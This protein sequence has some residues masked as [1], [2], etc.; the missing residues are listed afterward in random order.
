MYYIKAIL[1]ILFSYLYL[2]NPILILGGSGFGLI[3]L[4]YP[5]A[6]FYLIVK[7][8]LFV[9]FYQYRKELLLFL[10]IIL[11]TFSR[12][13]FTVNPF[14]EFYIK[15]IMLIEC[16]F[17]PYFLV[18]LFLNWFKSNRII[19]F[20]LAC[21]FVASLIT[22]LLITNP[23]LNL[24]F[25]EITFAPTSKMIDNF[26]RS[27]G[28]AEAL[29]FTYPILQGIFASISLFYI[30]KGFRY[31]VLF[32][33]LLVSILFNARIGF[34]PIFITLCCFLFISQKKAFY[35]ISFCSV[36]ML[37]FINTSFYQNN[38]ETMEWAREAFYNLSDVLFGTNL[39]TYD[40]VETLT[41]DM[42]VL[43]ETLNEWLWG[44]GESLFGVSSDVGYI[45]QLSY[46]GLVYCII[47]YTFF[48]YIFYQLWRTYSG[49]R[50]LI[51]ILFVTVTL[52]NVKGDILTS[53]A[54]T[55]FI[56]LLYIMTKT[57]LQIKK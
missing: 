11:Y 56:M 40:T 12:T 53:N 44:T 5:L 49:D 42:I 34:A 57:S 21:S 54:V 25:R 47:L 52:C 46:G 16:L 10:V 22:L 33:L 9:Y 35:I 6:F 8:K 43:P 55:R 1:F 7:N 14:T 29:N 50:S 51:F 4:L 20:L 24:Y 17:L 45:N 23:S 32:A 39:A 15:C 41:K 18:L 36:L 30:N 13:A 27:Y 38:I 26:L 2:Y 37:F 48:I 19:M 31:V 3:K 28:F